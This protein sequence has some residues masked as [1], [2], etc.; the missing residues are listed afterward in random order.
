MLQS[1]FITKK[2]VKRDVCINFGLRYS[3]RFLSCSAAWQWQCVVIIKGSLRLVIAKCFN[4]FTHCH[5]ENLRAGIYSDSC[6]LCQEFAD[7]NTVTKIKNFTYLQLIWPSLE[8]HSHFNHVLW[9]HDDDIALDFE[10]FER[11]I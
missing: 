7:N 5:R 9:N 3:L 10:V 2:F 11:Y 6:L 8:L 4:Q 1:W